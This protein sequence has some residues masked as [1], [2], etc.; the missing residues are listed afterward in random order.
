MLSKGNLG[1][2][3]LEIAAAGPQ[4][5][6]RALAGLVRELAIP[7]WQEVSPALAEIAEQLPATVEPASPEELEVPF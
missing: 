6:A 7:G 3:R 1:R 2:M 5:V 4:A